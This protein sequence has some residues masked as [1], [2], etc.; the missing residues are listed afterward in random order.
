MTSSIVQPQRVTLGPSPSWGLHAHH[1]ELW[2]W[3]STSHRGL[4]QHPI[5]HWLLSLAGTSRSA[6]QSR[7]S[8]HCHGAGGGEDPP[9]LVCQGHPKLGHAHLLPTSQHI[10][11]PPQTTQQTPALCCIKCRPFLSTLW[12]ALLLRNPL[13]QMTLFCVF[14]TIYSSSQLSFG[15]ERRAHSLLWSPVAHPIRVG[16]SSEK[17]VLRSALS[18]SPASPLCLLLELP[19]RFWHM[20]PY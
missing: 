12:A 13:P 3:N 17:K 15:G 5:P 6:V 10:P 16:R 1:P 8:A 19:K 18:H 14:F 7:A 11:T 4:L 9:S 2:A 20:Q